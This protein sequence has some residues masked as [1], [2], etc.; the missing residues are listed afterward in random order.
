[1][2]QIFDSIHFWY[3]KWKHR[4]L[5]K[6]MTPKKPTYKIL[7][8]IIPEDFPLCEDWVDS[9]S[10]KFI[11]DGW[12]TLYDSRIYAVMVADELLSQG[13][14]NDG[15]YVNSSQ[16]R[17]SFTYDD[18][19]SVSGYKAYPEDGVFPIVITQEEKCYHSERVRLIDEF[20]LFYDLRIVE[21][22]NGSIEYYQV[23][24][25]GEDILIAIANYCS[26]RA[27]ASYIQ[28]FIAIKGVNL[29]IQFDAFAYSNKQIVELH[30]EKTLTYYKAKDLFFSYSLMKSSFGENKTCSFVRGKSFLHHEKDSIKR[31][32]DSH[33]KRFKTFIAG[34]DKDGKPVYSTCN[35]MELKHLGNYEDGVPWQLSLV[36]F[37][38]EVLDKYYADTKKF[39]IKDGAIT[40]P[41]WFAHLDSDRSD[42]YVVMALKDLGKL[43]YKEQA[44]WKQYNIEYPSNASL[45]N[46]TWDRWIAGQPSDTKNAPD[47]LFKH[48]YEKLNSKW[49]EKFGF[50]LYLPLA[51]GDQH[52]YDELS[53]MNVLNNDSEFDKLILAFTK[54]TIDS[55]NEK[56]LFN[57]IDETNS[58][59]QEL[60]KRCQ[61]KDNKIS[62][63]ARGIKKL[64]GFMY[65]NE[66]YDVDFITILNKVQALRSTTAAHRKTTNPDKKDK[67]LATWFG[68]DRYPHKDV[69][70]KLFE[71]FIHQFEE[72]SNSLN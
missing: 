57:G 72:I 35:E 68:L 20:V 27:L 7:Q 4:K 55:L 70:D 65:S 21:R 51:S 9:A 10:K 19:E 29:V 6:H 34:K 15:W 38:R 45:S 31:L 54:V 24:E 40:G 59:V 11:T 25:N 42:G 14:D 46:T 23:D 18:G 52:F 50:P 16:M 8:E 1:M 62:N 66:I 56:G 39:S 48:L 36:F 22:I 28:E 67:G 26:L 53:S 71:R 44:H 37:K 30:G 2:L 32:W 60:C 63:L 13:E 41:Q 33:D 3:V 43:P 64:E 12:I 47:L 5:F 49:A 69:I 17:P 61:V 58:D